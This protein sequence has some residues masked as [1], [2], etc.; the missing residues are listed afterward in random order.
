MRNYRKRQIVKVYQQIKCSMI[1][2]AFYREDLPICRVMN[3]SY[4]SI[5]NHL[6][7]EEE[8]LETLKRR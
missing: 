6:K 2:G 4:C 7:S 3:R 8:V 1:K 5:L